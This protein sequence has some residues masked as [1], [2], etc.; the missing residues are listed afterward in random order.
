MIKRNSP[1]GCKDYSTVQHLGLKA[2][3]HVH[4]SKEWIAHLVTPNCSYKTTRQASL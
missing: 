1:L 3:D 4:M 2:E